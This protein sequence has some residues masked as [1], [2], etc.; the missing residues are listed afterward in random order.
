VVLAVSGVAALAVPFMLHSPPTAGDNGN[1]ADNNTGDIGGTETSNTPSGGND[2]SQTGGGGGNPGH[3]RGPN[4]TMQDLVNSVAACQTDNHGTQRS[5]Q[6]KVDSAI[7]AKTSSVKN[8]H[9]DML[10]HKLETP[11]AAKHAGACISSIE[12]IVSELRD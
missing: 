2:S 8:H 12:A 10:S 9:L 4:R 3:E 6:A 5:L 11:A 7:R 1:T